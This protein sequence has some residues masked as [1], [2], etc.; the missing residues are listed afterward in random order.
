MN[1]IAVLEQ[2][3]KLSINQSLQESGIISKGI[4]ELAKDEI[5]RQGRFGTNNDSDDLV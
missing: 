3:I 1:Q 4:Y 5:I 2:A